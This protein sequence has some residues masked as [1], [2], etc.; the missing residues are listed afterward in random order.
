LEFR[1]K[2]FKIES[3]LLL[4]ITFLS[5][6]GFGDYMAGLFLVAFIFGLFF[7]ENRKLMTSDKVLI[8]LLV[9]FTLNNLISSALSI[10]KV[11]SII[12]SFLW[13]LIIFIPIYYV[14]IVFNGDSEFFYKKIIPLSFIALS[15][16]ITIILVHF[17]KDL[18]EVGLKYKRYKYRLLGLQ[19][20]T[21]MILILTGLGYGWLRQKKKTSFLWIGLVYLIIG[22]FG[23]FLTADRGGMLSYIILSFILLSFDYKRLV[24]FII[25][26]FSTIFIMYRL[27]VGNMRHLF[28]YLVTKNGYKEVYYG[29]QLETFQQSWLLIKDHWLLGVGTGNFSKF[30]VKYGHKRWYAYAHNIILQFWAENGI[31]GMIFG[32]SIIGVIFYRWIYVMRNIRNYKYILL[33]IGST[34]MI[35]IISNMTNC[36]IWIIRIA[37][38]FWILAGTIIAEYFIVKNVHSD[39]KMS[40]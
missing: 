18:L 23:I 1:I 8:F 31:F 3:I 38:V 25:L 33:G 26:L 17:G 21:D 37:I 16:I 20:S 35:M 14:R 36:T 30:I 7:K 28:S 13:F 11:Q 6:V 2:K 4:V 34:F 10:N 15:I 5:W 24:L 12:L 29:H 27:D 22:G 39:E 32:L 40:L 9:A 19:S